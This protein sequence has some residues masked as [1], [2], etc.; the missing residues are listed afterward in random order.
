ML[1]KMFWIKLAIL[2]LFTV[3]SATAKRPF[4]RTACALGTIFSFFNSFS[5]YQMRVDHG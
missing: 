2:S 1:V 3:W 5:V 4:C